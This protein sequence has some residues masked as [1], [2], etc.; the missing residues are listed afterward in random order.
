[1]SG[2]GKTPILVDIIWAK[3]N[4]VKQEELCNALNR[5]MENNE[6]IIF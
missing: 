6:P 4:I 2:K 1:M 5:F 3:K